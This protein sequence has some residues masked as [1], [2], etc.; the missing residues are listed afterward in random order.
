M[1]QITKKQEKR[2]EKKESSRTTKQF[3]RVKRKHNENYNK[4][5]LV[6]SENFSEFLF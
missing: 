2:R 6:F 3:E 5:L 4:Q 1:K